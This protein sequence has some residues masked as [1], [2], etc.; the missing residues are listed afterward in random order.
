MASSGRS[1]SARRPR[2]P[3][4]Q[5]DRLRGDILEAAER[6]LL[7]G[8]D[9]Q[10]LSIRSVAGAVG[11]TPP[12]IYRHFEDK[13]ELLLAVCERR[14]VEFD[15]TVQAAAQDVEDPLLALRLRGEAYVR[16]GLTHPEHYRILFLKKSVV[17]GRRAA[18]RGGPGLDAFQHLVEAVQECM[19]AGRLDAGDVVSSSV[20]LW[21]ALHGLTSLLITMPEFEWPPVDSLVTR[22]LDATLAGLG[23]GQPRLTGI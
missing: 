19:D 23:A 1:T 13:D 10:T 3:R 8:A 5:G 9:E 16:F 17:V 4:G 21:S 12:A 6:L 20:C 15:A 7:E 11:V 18:E 22:M 2:A 14:F